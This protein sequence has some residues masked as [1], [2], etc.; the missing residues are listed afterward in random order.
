MALVDQVYAAAENAGLLMSCVWLRQ[1]G[2]P[3]EVQ[4][5]NFRAADETLLDGLTTGTEFTMTYPSSYFMGMGQDETVEI[6]GVR[7][8]VREVRAIHDGTELMAKL[9]SA[10]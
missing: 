3:P 10:T 9:A 1:A 7:Y 6:N 5:V 2:Y 4:G 8:V